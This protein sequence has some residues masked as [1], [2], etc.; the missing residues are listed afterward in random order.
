MKKQFTLISCLVL[1]IVFAPLV[2]FA[3]EEK[4][5]VDAQLI[6]AICTV[7]IAVAALFVVVWQTWATRKHNRLS[8]KPLLDINQVVRKAD[9]T[10]RLDLENNGVGP[11]IIKELEVLIDGRKV[12]ETVLK[13][14]KKIISI[15]DISCDSVYGVILSSDATIGAGSSVELLNLKVSDTQSYKLVFESLSRL[16]VIVKYESVYGESFSAELGE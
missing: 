1:C 5:E 12:E 8:V 10:V 4:G 6:T 11:A 2:V 15:I 14:W 13:N 16:N 7:I 3:G 9:S